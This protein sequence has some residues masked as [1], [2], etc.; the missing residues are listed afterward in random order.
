ML[1]GRGVLD[2][3]KGEAQGGEDRGPQAE[4]LEAELVRVRMAL[5]GVARTVVDVPR[6]MEGLLR[7]V[8]IT[9]TRFE[10]FE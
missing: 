2:G 1:D 9:P 8:G 5:D 10:H 6:M 7:K 3:R 4:S